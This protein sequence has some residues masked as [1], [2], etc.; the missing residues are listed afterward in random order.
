MTV[1]RSVLLAVAALLV[2]AC[3]WHHDDDDDRDIQLTIVNAGTSTVRVDVEYW[4]P[5]DYEYRT[6]IFDVP[7]G[8]S[9]TIQIFERWA[10]VLIFRIRDGLV[11]YHHELD[12]WDF[13]GDD[14]TIVVY[15]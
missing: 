12:W 6:T 3:H 13:E 11:L 4:D 9:W 8:Q 10:D 5:W 1:R 7:A 2:P 15:P 14:A